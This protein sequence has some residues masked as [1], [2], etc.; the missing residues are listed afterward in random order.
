[1]MKK[2]E[3]DPLYILLGED[4]IR[5]DEFIS[6]LKTSL[7]KDGVSFDFETIDC[8]ETEIS[9]LLQKIFTLPLFAAKRLVVLKNFSEIALDP[10]TEE[11]LFPHLSKIA[12]TRNNPVIIVIKWKWSKEEEL[13]IKRKGLSNYVINFYKGKDW[14]VKRDFRERAKRE[15]YSIDESALSFLL[16]YTGEDY[17]KAYQ[18][19]EKAKLYANSNRIDRTIVEEILFPTKRFSIRDFGNAFRNKERKTA[20]LA[21]TNLLLYKEKLENII[22]YLVGILFRLLREEKGGVW[23][24]REILSSLRDLA[25]IDKKMKTTS[26]DAETLLLNWVSQILSPP[27]SERLVD[28]L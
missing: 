26:C 14:A 19:Y 17:N 8:S 4:D 9:S 16:E 28:N 7:K 23:K 21:L 20:L 11:E 12:K 2:K 5:S 25:R 15:G 24:K 6:D 27:K 3:I 22:A 13:I 1:M 10:K 18:E